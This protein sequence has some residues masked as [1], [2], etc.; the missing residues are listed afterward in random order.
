MTWIFDGYEVSMLGLASSDLQKEFDIGSLEIGYIASSYLIGCCVGALLFGYL[1]SKY[2]RKSLFSIT[3]LIYLLSV[4]IQSF[5]SHYIP[6]LICRV[7]TG[8]I[9]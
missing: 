1:A 6:L 7:F 4:I 5:I 8:K 9:L 2:G 3:L